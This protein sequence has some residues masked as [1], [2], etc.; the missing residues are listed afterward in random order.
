MMVTKES[1][2]HFWG[3]LKLFFINS[4]KQFKIDG[5]PPYFS[6]KSNYKTNS[7]KKVGI[8]DLSKTG[9]QFRYLMLAQ[10]YFLTTCRKV[11]ACSP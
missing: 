7:E 4:L 3:D 8:K 2:E 1:Y 6:K 9:D 11:E 10:K 5:Y